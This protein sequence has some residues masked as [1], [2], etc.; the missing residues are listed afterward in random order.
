M[1]IFECLEEEILKGIINDIPT[2]LPTIEDVQ[3]FIQPPDP[4][5]EY[6]L[7]SLKAFLKKLEEIEWYEACLIVLEEI[8]K[9]Q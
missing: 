7:E 3:K 5:P 4:F 9:I 8:Q 2:F 6:R 1:K